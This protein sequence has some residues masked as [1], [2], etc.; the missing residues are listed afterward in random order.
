MVFRQVPRTKTEQAVI[1]F[2]IQDNCYQILAK[3]A[4]ILLDI[5]E[6]SEPRS[7]SG[8]ANQRQ[9]I[10]LDEFRTAWSYFIASVLTLHF[11]Q[12]QIK[13][14]DLPQ[15]FHADNYTKTILR[16]V[17]RQCTRGINHFH[18]V[19]LLKAAAYS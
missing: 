10:P 9:K 14:A 3:H 1:C 5:S 15:G 12:E 6:K 7:E 11:Y 19:K 16:Y 18:I 13:S 17:D 4:W 2:E 8:S